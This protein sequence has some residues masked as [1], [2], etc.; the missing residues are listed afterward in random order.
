MSI[1]GDQPPLATRIEKYKLLWQ[2][3]LDIDLSWTCLQ[4]Y[5]SGVDQFCIDF[6]ATL[7]DFFIAAMVWTFLEIVS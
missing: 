5:Y 7:I 1:I 6:R 4:S 2:N 3:V